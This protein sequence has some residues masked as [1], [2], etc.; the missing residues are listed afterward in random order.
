LKDE[1][2]W[3]CSIDKPS[4]DDA[5]APATQRYTVDVQ[6]WVV[7]RSSPVSDVRVFHGRRL[8]GISPLN[9]KRPDVAERFPSVEGAERSGFAFSIGLI[10]LPPTCELSL[11]ALLED[12]ADVELGTISIERSAYRTGYEP[13][14]VPIMVTTL[15]R[16]GSTVLVHML[17]RLPE[18]VAY[19]PLAREPRAATYWADVLRHLSNPASY[20]RGLNHG[21]G[22]ATDG[23]WLPWSPP[24]PEPLGDEQL[25]DLLGGESVLA[26]ARLAQSRLDELYGLI[27]EREG[28]RRARYFA[29]KFNPQ[30][31]ATVLRELYPDAREIFLVRD[32]R[33]MACSMLS[34]SGR[35]IDGPDF[36][37]YV[38][39][40]MRGFAIALL[41]AWRERSSRSLLVRYEDLMMKSNET[42]EA[43]LDYLDLNPADHMEELISALKEKAPGTEG[44][45]TTA[46]PEQSIGRWKRD[47]SIDAQEALSRELGDVLTAFG[48]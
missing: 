31:A 38:A 11:R 33:D 27:A 14:L 45:R 35:E 24:A 2:I 9:R 3:G 47:L 39:G 37:S 26:L 16:S 42:V 34:Y 1:R 19:R 48:Y 20:R 7:G 41:E 30:I 10:S 22:F 5:R 32:F 44:H 23:W 40:S 12:G 17:S 29:E 4:N 18:V 15:G 13:R 28:K 43:V 36:E 25:E 6:G 46:S 21:G 8:C